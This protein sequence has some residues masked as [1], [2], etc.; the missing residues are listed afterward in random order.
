MM[1][2]WTGWNRIK[3]TWHINGFILFTEEL[4]DLSVSS[5]MN[6]KIICNFCLPGKESPEII[7]LWS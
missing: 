6:I 7:N 3:E 5:G 2:E 4:L 1:I